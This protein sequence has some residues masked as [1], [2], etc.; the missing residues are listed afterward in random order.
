MPRS[1]YG[2]QNRQSSGREPRECEQ[3]RYYEEHRR[4]DDFEDCDRRKK[5]CDDDRKDDKCPHCHDWCKCPPPWWFW[6]REDKKHDECDEDKH[7]NDDVELAA[8]GYV[9][10]LT[11]TTT[12]VAP[13]TDVVFSNNGPLRNITHAPGTPQVLIQK[14]GVYQVY[15]GVN[16]TAGAGGFISL[17]VNG[18]V[19][20]AT[21]IPVATVPSETSG[22]V[23]LSLRRGDILTLR[24]SSTLTTITL[25]AAPSVGAQLTLER[26]GDINC[27]S[28]ND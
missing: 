8:F 28:E 12:A 5:H 19:D 15:Y 25:A 6:P 2:E 3:R 4:F 26:I 21:T 11:T 13:N 10:S 17:A 20:P 24:N 14:S 1:E 27:R 16:A 18:I 9:Y 22:K 7:R 23:L